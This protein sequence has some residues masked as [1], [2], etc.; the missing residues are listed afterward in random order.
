M[1]KY[2]LWCVC[3]VAL[4]AN[5]NAA[6]SQ[7]LELTIAN[8][9]VV[10][11][12]F[13]FDIMMKA[14]EGIVYLGSADLVLQFNAANFTSPS[15]SYPG[16]FSSTGATFPLVSTN[17]ASVGI[18]Y[19]GC[20]S[21]QNPIISNEIII[22]VGQV[23]GST[24]AQFDSRVAKLSTGTL[25]QFG[26]YT[27][28][29]ITNAAGSMGLTFKTSGG[30]VQTHVSTLARA[31]WTATTVTLT[32]PAATNSPLPVELT[33]FTAAATGHRVELS[34]A[35]A[36]ENNNA[37]FDVQRRMVAGKD[38]AWRTVTF[39]KG[40]GTT[41]APQA[42]SV[43]DD[44]KIPAKYA[45]RLKQVDAGG[46]IEYSKEVEAVVAFQAQDYQLTA[47]Y[48]NPFNPT[49]TFRFAVAKAERVAVK[50]FNIIGQEVCTMFNDVATPD[51]MYTLTFDASGLA[52]G[53]YFYMLKTQD[54]CEVK[55]MVLMK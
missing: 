2:S 6:S 21:P 42:Y 33:T 49:T 3:A 53:T 41:S 11:T 16:D 40:H 7:T 22:N 27:I 26:R 23:T 18:A 13:S 12:D 15:I 48:P 29:G 20:V 14:T 25:Y 37:G 47:N 45:Y 8:Q 39:A 54:R 4:A 50:V 10:G 46:K 31:T 35:T 1:K 38:N 30:G 55:K 52:S 28:S 32:T 43:K 9:Q 19:E 5:F 34:W 44:V 24:Q 51:M 17:L 36:T